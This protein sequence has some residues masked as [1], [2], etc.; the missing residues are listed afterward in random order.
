[1]IDPEPSEIFTPKQI[2]D[3]M[4]AIEEIRRY[5][6]HGELIIVFYKGRVRFIR[7]MTGREYSLTKDPAN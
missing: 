6:G 1:M 3:I 5:G 4:E 2:A 7:H